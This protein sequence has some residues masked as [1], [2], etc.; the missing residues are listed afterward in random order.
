MAACST[1]QSY[2]FHFNL[3]S[4]RCSH[5]GP[6]L[7]ISSTCWWPSLPISSPNL[8]PLLHINRCG[9]LFHVSTGISK[10]ISNFCSPKILHLPHPQSC[11]SQYFPT[12][13]KGTT[14][15]PSVQAKILKAIFHFFSVTHIQSSASYVILISKSILLPSLPSTCSSHQHL[16]W[17]ALLRF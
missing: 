1:A 7:Q 6:W 9:F 16:S 10:S 4:S 17:T 15:H 5:S 13:V 11:S 12:K 8:F 14:I 2:F 3:L